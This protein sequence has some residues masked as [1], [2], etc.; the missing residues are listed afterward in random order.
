MYDNNRAGRSLLARC[1]P[2][3]TYALNVTKGINTITFSAQTTSLMERR[4]PTQ[5]VGRCFVGIACASR[6]DTSCCTVSGALVTV[7][8]AGSCD[9]GDA[10]WRCELVA[11]ADK[12]ANSTDNCGAARSANQG[13]R[14]AR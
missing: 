1:A 7:V 2:D 8:A 13:F 5:S 12:V 11:A 9:F 10:G 14:Y 3:V 6:H 4:G